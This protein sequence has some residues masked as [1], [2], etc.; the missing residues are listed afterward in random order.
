MVADGI[1]SSDECAS[2][3]R[4]LDTHVIRFGKDQ[5][6]E[7][8]LD[9]YGADYGDT[10]STKFTSE[11]K[12]TGAQQALVAA[13]HDRVQRLVE[14]Y[15]GDVLRSDLSSIGRR[16]PGSKGQPVHADSCAGSHPHLE[17]RP[18]GRCEITMR[19][20]YSSIL[21]LSESDGGRNFRG[22]D[23]FFASNYTGKARSLVP[24]RCGRLVA[25][26]SDG[27]NWHGVSGM[28]RGTLPDE[29][30][31]LARYAYAMWWRRGSLSAAPGRFQL[32][33]TGDMDPGQGSLKC[34][35]PRY[36]TEPPPP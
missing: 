34:G 35:G 19:R 2:L 30:Q 32:H 16:E 6:G 28:E 7:H 25:F 21:Y 22:A 1:M 3:R 4:L 5:I 12:G 14:A 10:M 36:C 9:L 24:P 20:A 27:R 13:A 15:F 23:F 11:L 18:G 17:L 26:H 8:L 31:P 29:S 33:M